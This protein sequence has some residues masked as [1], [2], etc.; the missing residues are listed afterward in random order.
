ML[1][2][3]PSKAACRRCEPVFDR[4]QQFGRRQ[5]G[6][7]N[8]DSQHDVG[9]GT[10][11]QDCL[12]RNEFVIGKRSER[13]LNSSRSLLS[14]AVCRPIV[15]VNPASSAIGDQFFDELLMRFPKVSDERAPGGGNRLALGDRLHQPVEIRQ[16]AIS[17]LIERCS[18]CSASSAPMLC[19]SS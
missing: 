11:L 19:V 7:F 18:R 1:S 6:R 9:F 14:A 2:R 3:S 5:V 12:Q 13:L 4:W 17:R 15:K 8:K 10:Q 16:D